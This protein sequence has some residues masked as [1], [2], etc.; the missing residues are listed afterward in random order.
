MEAW[1]QKAREALRRHGHRA[2]FER[3]LA[4]NDARIRRPELDNGRELAAERTAIYLAAVAAWAERE[5]TA[6]GYDRPFAVVAIGGTGRGEMAPCSDNDFALLFDDELEGNPF[7]AR[8]QQQILQSDQFEREFGF[9]CY[10]L[11]F[12]LEAVPD[13]A[14]KQL[15]AFLDM[16]PVY[17]PHGL[18]DLF[19]ERIRATC[20][21]FEHFLHVRGFWKDTGKRRPTNASGWTGSTSKT[22]ACACSWRASGPWPASDSSTAPRFTPRWTTRATWPPMSS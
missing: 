10:A 1:I 16:R 17:D 3:W 15:N 4:A 13:L 19:R 20:D 5:R 22:T 14:G 9:V 18:A 7:L 21:T 2:A 12:N 6:F 8:L 11:P